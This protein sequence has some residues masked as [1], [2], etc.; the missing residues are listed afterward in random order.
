MYRQGDVLI[1]AVANIPATAQP[2]KLDRNRIVLAY[3]EVTGHAH[4]IEDLGAVEA[5]EDNGKVYLRIKGDAA[6]KHEEHGAIH[7]PV[8][9]YR[10]TIQREYSPEAIR[11]VQD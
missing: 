5:F 4:A 7:L 10:V 6:V 2:Y 11:N 9:L 3:G 8:G 1:H